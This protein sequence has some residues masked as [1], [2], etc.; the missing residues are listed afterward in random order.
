MFH[1]F[2]FSLSMWAKNGP[3][4]RNKRRIEKTS[5]QD[6]RENEVFVD[7]TKTEAITAPSVVQVEHERPFGQSPSKRLRIA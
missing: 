4:R 1:N 6:H 5:R 3:L 2:R 7:A